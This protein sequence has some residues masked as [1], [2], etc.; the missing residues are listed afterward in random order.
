M[1]TFSIYSG[2]DVRKNTYLCINMPTISFIIPYYNV[3]TELLRECVESILALPLKDGEREII[4][5]DDGSAESPDQ[6]LKDYGGAVSCVRQENGGASA[7][8]NTGLERAT[9]QYIQFVDADDML[10]PQAYSA[11][12]NLLNEHR[13]DILLFG[14]TTKREKLIDEN[15]A[16]KRS[17]VMY[18]PSPLAFEGGK[19]SADEGQGGQCF[20]NR[21]NLPT[22]V[23]RYLLSRKTLGDLRFTSGLLHED[24]EFNPLLF[25]RAGTVVE[26]PLTAYYYRMRHDSMMHRPSV[27]HLD[28]RL[29]DKERIIHRLS[30]EKR[31]ER[32]TAQ[33]TMDYIY[34]TLTL[35]PSELR[36]RLRR[37][38]KDGFYPL[39]VRNYTMKYLAFSILSHIMR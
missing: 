10:I 36:G 31:L 8:R 9:G 34:D 22:V 21:R 11:C 12:L 7:A 5:V 20:L 13:P 19:S 38:R 23:W 27:E 15:I 39:P 25:L 29:D 3:P 14:F 2:C 17:V 16:A 33:L 4:V 30:G 35:R 6:V 18:P 1:N 28:R 26:T 37:L 24:E 32:R